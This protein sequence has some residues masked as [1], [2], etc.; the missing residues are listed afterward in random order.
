MGAQFAVELARQLKLLAAAPG[1]GPPAALQAALWLRAA[2]LPPLLPLV[3]SDRDQSAGGNL[4]GLIA[5]T[6]LTCVSPA[7]PSAPSSA[8]HSPCSHRLLHTNLYRQPVLSCWVLSC[9]CCLLFVGDALVDLIFQ[10][11]DGT[12]KLTSDCAK[13][14]AGVIADWQGRRGCAQTQLQIA[15]VG[16]TWQRQRLR[17]RWRPERRGSPS[18]SGLQPSRRACCPPRGRPGCVATR[19]APVGVFSRITSWAVGTLPLGVYA[20]RQ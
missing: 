2:L 13:G 17:R 3:Y 7:T 16:V 11:N 6:L 5:P 20:V 4:R 18:H 10:I 14:D 19:W 12:I 8:Q 15:A 9:L 1:A